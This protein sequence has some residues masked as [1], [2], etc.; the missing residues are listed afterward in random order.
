LEL[1]VKV[2]E[3]S[4]PDD[5]GLRHALT[6]GYFQ[7]QEV[8]YTLAPTTTGTTLRLTCRYQVKSGVNPYAHAWV[9]AILRDFER[10]LLR[11]LKSRAERNQELALR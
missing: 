7:I 2:D 3:G 11:A 4:I 10:N 5:A 9:A 6:S 8:D 1:E